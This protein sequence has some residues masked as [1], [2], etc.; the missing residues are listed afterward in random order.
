MMLKHARTGFEAPIVPP[1][2]GGMPGNIL[3]DLERG[4]YAVVSE[5][6]KAA[7]SL[8]ERARLHLNHFAD[9]PFAQKRRVRARGAHA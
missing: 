9:C 4:T 7:L 8:E 3:V 5:A 6:E 2:V 1:K